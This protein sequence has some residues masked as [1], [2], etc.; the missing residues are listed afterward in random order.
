MFLEIILIMVGLVS[1]IYFITMLITAL[2]MKKKKLKIYI[3]CMII[4]IIITFVGYL[5]IPIQ[6]QSQIAKN[7]TTSDMEKET[8]SSNIV[9]TMLKINFIDNGDNGCILL[10]CGEKN[11]LIDSGKAENIKEIESA[12]K[13]HSVNT[14]Y[15]VIITSGDDSNMGAAAKIISDYKVQE[16][17]YIDDSIKSNSHYNELQAAVNSNGLELNKIESKYQIGD[18]D[19]EASD[20]KDNI[21]LKFSIPKNQSN[22]KNMSF[23]KDDF[24]KTSGI[25]GIKHDVSTSCDSEGNF[26]VIIKTYTK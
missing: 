8:L 25:S 2:I 17:R 20:S 13:A 11:I 15:S 7:S 23:V 22:L 4:G 12:L 1:T 5:K 16:V 19:V 3:I 18:I 9:N 24:N 6:D 10:Q 21:K 14:L 26:N